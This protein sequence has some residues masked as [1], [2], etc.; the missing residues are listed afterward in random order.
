MRENYRIML[1]GPVLEDTHREAVRRAVRA[2][3][4]EIVSC[5]PEEPASGFRLARQ[6]FAVSGGR[7]DRDAIQM[8]LLALASQGAVSVALRQCRE[9]ASCGNGRP[10]GEDPAAVG[11]GGGSRDFSGGM[12]PFFRVIA[13]DMDST[14]IPGELMNELGESMGIGEQMRRIT[15]ET[16]RGTLDF[17][18]SFTRRVALLKGLEAEALERLIER[19]PVAPGLARAMEA[20][21]RAGMG[22]AVITGGFT[23]FGRYLQR[24]YGFDEIHT[25]DIEIA[26]G[27]LTGRIVGPVM[28]GAGKAAALEDFCRR[29]NVPPERCVAVGDGANDLPMLRRSGMAVAYHA[30]GPDLYRVLVTAGCLPAPDAS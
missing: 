17:R 13:F 6:V 14:L 26:A 11:T 2:G 16:V 24:R 4:A 10:T 5:T 20:L 19:M 12:E 21:R 30:A 28:D 9:E 29:R 18:R 8:E 23:A 7:P 3:G 22:T 25:T 27:R 15:A 1:L